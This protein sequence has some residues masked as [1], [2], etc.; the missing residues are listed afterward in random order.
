MLS[1]SEA[2]KLLSDLCVRL[3][4]CLPP[5]EE[6]RLQENPPLDVRSFTDAVF[7]AEGLNPETADRHLYRQVRNMVAAAYWRSEDPGG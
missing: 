5:E 6:L 4:F 1:E 3:G 2:S 7:V